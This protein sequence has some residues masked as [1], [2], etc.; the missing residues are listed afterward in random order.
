MPVDTT[1]LALFIVAALTICITP[2]PDM[3][4][5]LANGIH[6]GPKAGVISALGMATGMLCHTVAAA[7]GLAALFSASPVLYKIVQY[8]GAAYLF[9]IGVQTLRDPVFTGKV[10][11]REHS[12]LFTIWQRAVITNLLNPKIILFYVAFLPQFVRSTPGLSSAT[13]QFIFLGLTFVLLGLMVDSTL[14]ILSGTLNTVLVQNARLS[15]S[16]NWFSALVFIGLAVRLVL[17]Q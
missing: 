14:G 10:K 6:Q 5:V 3:L 11:E 2:G 13:G 12:S 7:L 1:A 17:T 15:R 8:A 4:Y 9:W 16:L